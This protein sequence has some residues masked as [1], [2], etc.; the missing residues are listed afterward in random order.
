MFAMPLFAS[1]MII[2]NLDV[3]RGALSPDETNSPLI[4]DSDA[5]LPF[6]VAA[7]GLEPVSRNSGDVFQVFCVVEQPQLSARDLGNVAE[8]PVAL[9]V[10]QLLSV[11]AAEGADH[12]GSI[13]RCP[14][15]D[16][17]YTSALPPSHLHWSA[18]IK[19]KGFQADSAPADASHARGAG[20]PRRTMMT[21]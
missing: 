4:I 14:F 5:L 20:G 1:L 8:P 12:T 13:S 18:A 10:E 6:P 3:L 17:H 15:N 21:L 11:P 2:D 19:S 16:N 7:Q 9:A